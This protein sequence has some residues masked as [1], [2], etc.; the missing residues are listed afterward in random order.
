MRRWSTFAVAV[1]QAFVRKAELEF[2]LRSAVVVIKV[3]CE[4]DQL[5][6]SNL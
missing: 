1:L 3:Q 4:N 6:T 2:L 5:S